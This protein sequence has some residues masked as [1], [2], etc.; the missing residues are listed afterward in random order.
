MGGRQGGETTPHIHT[1]TGTLCIAS[2]VAN[3]RTETG[4]IVSRPQ[5]MYYPV[6]P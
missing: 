3:G 4:P 1:R 2:L 6:P 5:L